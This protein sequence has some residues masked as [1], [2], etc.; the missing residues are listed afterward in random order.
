MFVWD[1]LIAVLPIYAKS[2]GICISAIVTL[3]RR[4]LVAFALII[5]EIFYEA[6]GSFE[7]CQTTNADQRFATLIQKRD[8][9]D[10]LVHAASRPFK[11]IRWNST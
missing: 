7:S 1:R 3:H 4:L 6:F 9:Y 5:V 10:Q 11:Y 8:D 2:R